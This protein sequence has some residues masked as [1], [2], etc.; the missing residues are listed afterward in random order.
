MNN[1]CHHFLARE[2][3]PEREVELDETEDIELVRYPLDQVPELIASGRIDHALVLS[4]FFPLFRG[5]LGEPG[6]AARRFE[7]SAPRRKGARRSTMPGKEVRKPFPASTPSRPC[8]PGPD[9]A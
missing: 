5:R 8:R 3:V 4:A 7:K 6:I 2:V 1:W 9:P